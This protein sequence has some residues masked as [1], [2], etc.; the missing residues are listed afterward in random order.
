MKP[1]QVQLKGLNKY[2]GKYQALKDL[3]AT[4]GPGVVGI[5]GPNGA[6]KTTLIRI[7]TGLIP[8]SSGEVVVNGLRIPEEIHQLR[9]DLGYLPQ[10]FGLYDFLN[11][12]EFLDYIGILRG[13]K[14]TKARHVEVN[15]VLEYVNMTESASKKL[16]KMSGGMRQRIGIAQAIMGNP[17][18]RIFDEPTA[19]LDPSE[20]VRFWK[21]LADC[22]ETTCVLFSTHIV[23]DV[24]NLCEKVVVLD[25]GQILFDGN[26]SDLSKL[27][28]GY[29][30]TMV[31]TKDELAQ[32]EEDVLI[33]STKYIIGQQEV[34]AI[35]K[36]KPKEDA[37]PIEPTLEDSYFMLLRRAI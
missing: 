7:L 11:A 31:T 4:W 29:V 21:L 12:Y 22:A 20:R 8:P 15:R 25:H 27:A 26:V 16:R 28:R 33:V 19:G 36:N 14:D 24:E 5:L 34:R 17:Q 23:A 32:M 37:M 6:G 18:F 2:Y 9:D 30:W 1:V 13:M 35:S 10:R 3:D